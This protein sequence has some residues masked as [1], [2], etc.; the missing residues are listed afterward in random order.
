MANF[1]ARRDSGQARPRDGSMANSW[2][3][4]VPALPDAVDLGK[5]KR[6]PDRSEALPEMVEVYFFMSFA[7]SSSALFS[8]SVLSSSFTGILDRISSVR[9]ST[10]TTVEGAST[11]YFFSIAA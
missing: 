7:A 4:L 9:G 2:R 5:E 1:S 10:T 8:A 11:S 3:F 6:A